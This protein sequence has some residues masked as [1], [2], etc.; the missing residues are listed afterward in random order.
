MKFPLKKILLI[1]IAAIAIFFVVTYA[2]QWG[3]AVATSK[4]KNY[5]EEI[6]K[7]KNNPVE[8]AAQCPTMIKNIK[9]EISTLGK[10]LSR[11]DLVLKQKMIADCAL[12]SKD[13]KTAI[14]NYQKVINAGPNFPKPY[15]LYSQALEGSGDLGNALRYAH[16]AVQLA[17]NKYY[18]RVTEARLLAKLNKTVK[19]IDAYQAT[20][21]VAPYKKAPEIR[22]ELD[23]LV[24]SY[25]LE[26]KVH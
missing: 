4:T 25:N 18:T 14:A 6:K 20:L 19:A 5:A 3:P 12:A 22:Q 23:R 8:A 16:L 13:Y 7:L 9:D 17:P 21:K 1:F 2:S 24:L 15:V 26:S 11:N 10:K